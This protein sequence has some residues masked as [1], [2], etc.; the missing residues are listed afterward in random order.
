MVVLRITNG[1]TRLSDSKLISRANAILQSMTSNSNFPT[2]SPTL[3]AF[4]TAIN[5]F[6]TALS[7]AENGGNYDKAVKN[8]K[9]DE[10]IDILHA[11]GAYVL[12]TSS[13]LP[14]PFLAAK[15]SGFHVAKTGSPKVLGTV[16]NL[17]LSDGV[18]P[19][20]LAI[21]FNTVAGS[22]AFVYLYTD[23]ASLSETSWRVEVGT[24]RKV[25]LSGLE[26]GK[27]YFV[28]IIAIGASDQKVVSDVVSR[29]IQ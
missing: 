8:Q 26:S 16:D 28:R 23:D 1:F 5:D 2:P 13:N 24:S 12:F 25:V 4:Q 15:S 20:E 3:A 22:R 9:R 6:V 19:G 10:L 29:L 27:K 11:L 14:D 21:S 7:E 17:Q 18:N